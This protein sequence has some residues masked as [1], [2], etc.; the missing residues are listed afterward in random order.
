MD[1]TQSG[2]GY[3]ARFTRLLRL[4][5]GAVILLHGLWIFDSQ[6]LAWGGLSLLLHSLPLALQVLRRPLVRVYALWFGVLLVGQSLLSPLLAGDYV[7]LPPNMNSSVDLRTADISGMPAGLRRITTDAL[8]YRTAPPVDYERK[9]GTRIFAIGGSTTEGIILD[10]HATWP[11]RLQE[12]LQARGHAVEVIN[13]GVS[14]LRARNHVATLAAAVPYQPDLAIVMVGGNDW[15][16]H[17]R[18]EFEPHPEP[19]TPAT[20]RASAL[21]KL[22]SRGVVAPLR[23]RLGMPAGTDRHLVLVDPAA[24]NANRPRRSLDRPDRRVFRPASVSAGYREDMEALSRGCKDLRVRCLFLTHPHSYSRAA[25]QMLRDS[26]WMTP[27]DAR[28]TLDMASMLHVA[29]L[30]N[31]WLLEFARREGHAACDVAAG[32]EASSELFYDDMHLTDLGARRVAE[33]VLPCVER[34]LVEP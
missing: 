11:S 18:D 33:L 29:S 13:T 31:G 8:G 17:I 19:Y 15:N 22:L 30:Y 1:S 10:D 6:S 32:V 28:Y 20:L 24:V 12:G 9:S 2:Q 4:T 16:K 23:A 34:A 7:S 26:Y 21:G 27:P 5:L 14:G 25:T 3:E